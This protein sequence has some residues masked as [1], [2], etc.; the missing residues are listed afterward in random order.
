DGSAEIQDLLQFAKD[1]AASHEKRRK[2][3][4]AALESQKL[5]S[6]GDF[7]QAVALLESTLKQ[8]PDEELKV[9]LAEAKRA[10]EEYEKKIDTTIA[11]AQKLLEQRKIDEAVIFLEGQA[12]GL[13]RSSKFAAVLEKARTEQDQAKG[14]SGAMEKARTA[15]EKN[16]FAGALKI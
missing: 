5:M 13:G 9:V 8:I 15:L 1:E 11:K 2:I 14:V 7:E 16:D 6:D 4:S 10:L 3:D 12:K